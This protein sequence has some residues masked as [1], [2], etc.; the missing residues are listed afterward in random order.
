MHRTR[1][2]SYVPCL[3]RE[4]QLQPKPEPPNL[5]LNQLSTRFKHQAMQSAYYARC[6]HMGAAK[7]NLNAPTRLV[8]YPIATGHRQD[9]TWLMRAAIALL[10]FV[11]SWT[12]SYSLRAVC[13]ESVVLLPF[14]I[15]HQLRTGFRA[16][17]S[18]GRH[19]PFCLVPLK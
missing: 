5:K 19:Q 13:A 18:L 2:P 16:C 15:P 3:Q 8:Q 9:C 12:Q 17:T 7:R 4:H 6:S 10:A 1:H 11:Y 14:P